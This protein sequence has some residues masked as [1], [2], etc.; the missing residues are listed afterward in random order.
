[1]PLTRAELD[2]GDFAQTRS[3][4]RD[5]RPDAIINAAAFTRV[6]DCETEPEQ[7]FRINALAVRN[8]AQLCAELGGILVHVSTDYVFDGEK[9]APYAE[10]DLPSPVSLY[11]VSKLAGEYFVRSRVPRHYVVRTCGLYGVAGTG[12]R[13][14]NFV[15]TMLRL[16]D[17]GRPIRVVE[18]QVLTPSWARDVARKMVQLLRTGAFGLYHVTNRGQCSWYEFAQ[19]IFA[20]AGLAPRLEPTT[21]AAYGAPARRP[22]YSVLAHAKLAGMGSDDLPH[23]RDALAAYLHERGRLAASYRVAEDPQKV[24]ERTLRE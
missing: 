18:D 20:L 12:S 7:A 5:I 4:L 19:A 21:A 16:A 22:R 1:M 10:D 3:R 14:G 8:L 9:G 6:D 24:T 2:I 15:E 13:R 11:G 23:W 17:Q